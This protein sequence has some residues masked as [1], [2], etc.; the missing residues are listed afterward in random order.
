MPPRAAVGRAAVGRSR[1]RR[2]TAVRGENGISEDVD[3]TGLAGTARFEIASQDPDG[4]IPAAGARPVF[5]KETTEKNRPLLSVPFGRIAAALDDEGG[6]GTRRPKGREGRDG[7]TA[8]APRVGNSRRVRD[9]GCRPLVGDVACSEGGGLCRREE[10]PGRPIFGAR[11]RRERFRAN[12]FLDSNGH[13]FCDSPGYGR[14]H[15][16][17]SRVPR[18]GLGNRGGAD[19]AVVFTPSYVCSRIFWCEGTSGTI[20]SGQ[21]P[22]FEWACLRFPGLLQDT[23]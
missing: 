2:L 22:W 11:E 21:P 15:L 8:G 9:T 16:A 19:T 6:G 5:G 4:G 10:D 3:G 18:N 20:L 13:F 23:S 12:N 14:K 17:A 1:G 7:T